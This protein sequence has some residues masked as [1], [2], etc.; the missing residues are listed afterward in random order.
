MRALCVP[1]E[2]VHRRRV[3]VFASSGLFRLLRLRQRHLSAKVLPALIL[4][5][6]QNRQVRCAVLSGDLWRHFTANQKTTSCR[7]VLSWMGAEAGITQNCLVRFRPCGLRRS[8]PKIPGATSFRTRRRSQPNL[9][10]SH[11]ITGQ[12][13]GCS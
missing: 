11:K 13:G 3:P 12:K 9:K 2:M 1:T 8:L 4:S 10:R 7:S 5:P 6:H